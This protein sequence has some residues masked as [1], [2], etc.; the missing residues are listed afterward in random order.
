VDD[1]EEMEGGRSKKRM[2]QGVHW[3]EREEL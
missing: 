1:K 2:L 3:R